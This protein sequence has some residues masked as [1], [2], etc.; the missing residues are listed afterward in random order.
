VLFKTAASIFLLFVSFLVLAPTS[1]SQLISSEIFETEEDLREGLEME[2]LTFDQYLELLD[3]MQSRLYPASGETDKLFLIPDVSNFDLLMLR[4]DRM[5]ISLDQKMASFLAK[6]PREKNIVFAGR[7]KWRFYERFEEDGQVDNYLLV[8]VINKK[9]FIWHIQA[10]QETNSSNAFAS[11]GDPKIRKRFLKLLFPR[12]QGELI[13]G[14]FDK[15]IGMGINVGY[16]P[17]FGYDSESESHSENSFLYPTRGRFNGIY[18]DVKYSYLYAMAFF[19]QNR[20]GEIEN[21]IGALHLSYGNRRLVVGVCASKGELENIISKSTFEDDCGSFHF[22]LDLKPLRL[23]GEYA[24]LSNSENGWALDV[25]SHRRIFSFDLSLW[26][27]DDDFIHPHGGGLANP[28]YETIYIE[29]ADFDYRSRQAGERGVFFKSRYHT[30]DRFK[31]YLSYNQWRERSYRPDKMKFKVG[32]GYVFSPGLS[33]TAS[34]LW[35]DYD[36]EDE[37]MDRSTSSLNLF[38]SPHKAVDF[39]LIANYRSAYSKNY[40]DIRLKTKTYLFS[41]FEFVIWL[42][43]NDNNFAQSTDGYLTFHIQENLIFSEKYFVSAEYIAKFYQDESRDDIRSAR[44]KVEI[45]W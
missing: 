23:S 2:F 38:L 27:Y 12:H 15:R 19:S 10:D 34:Q 31:F 21:R 13:L 42:K 29:Q 35:T 30:S 36:V 14:N 41:P 9:R 24:L 16:H 40:G 18:G 20:R 6:A 1:Y 37:E 3:M 17:L 26:S 45:L 5:D 39:N 32:T 8:E 43:Y 11:S 25:F 7:L 4:E 33:L 28:D 44:V 22:D